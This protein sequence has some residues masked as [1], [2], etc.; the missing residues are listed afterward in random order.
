MLE[1]VIN[2]NGSV[3]QFSHAEFSGSGE[4]MRGGMVMVSEFFRRAGWDVAGGPWEAGA[5]PV[6]MVRREW[7]DVVGFSLGAEFHLEALGDCIQAVRKAALNEHIGII[8]GGPIFT[9]HPEFVARV[10]ADAATTDGRQA[11]E[12]AEQVAARMKQGC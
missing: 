3:A 8:V 7:F 2:G 5:D 11:P 1:S 4:W 6:V 12:M 9:L 10:G